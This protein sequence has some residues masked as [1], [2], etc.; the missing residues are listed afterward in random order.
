MKRSQIFI[1]A[2]GII[3]LTQ[4]CKN[5]KEIKKE[6]VRFVKAENLQKN[7]KD[8]SK[9][10]SAFVK[11]SKESDLAFRVGGPLK[12]L[13]VEEGM[14]V[15][16]GQILACIDD[17]D[18]IINLKAAKAQFEQRKGEYERFQKLFEQKSLP[19]NTKDQVEAAYKLAKANYEK[20]KNALNDTKLTAPFSGYIHTRYVENFENVNP[21]ENIVNLIDIKKLEVVLSVSESFI[22][23]QKSFKDFRC[24]FKQLGGLN[25]PAKLK[26]INKKAKESHLY[27]IKLSID[28]DVT[29][30]IKPGMTT[31]VYIS[32]CDKCEETKGFLISSNAVWN[33][34]NKN[35][36]WSYNSSTKTVHKKQVKSFE[37]LNN[38]MALINGNFRNNET[39]ITA[40]TS[41][42]IEG[43]KVKILGS[44][45]ATN[46]GGQI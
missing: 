42:L 38:G 44:K 19:A 16:K 10:F 1:V 23:Y 2:L 24:E 20:A 37:I 32:F 41:Y 15:K 31:T 27:E 29:K 35:Y 7:T 34:E 14:Y 4:S 46:V 12:E 40:G 18:Y 11:E 30:R 8:K 36:V 25:I 22:Q 45:S 39:I 43:Q 33:N 6:N 5:D 26:E 28:P 3:A 9:A 13:K 21:G 17:R